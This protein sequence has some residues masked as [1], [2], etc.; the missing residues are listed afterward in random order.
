MSTE[1][2]LH[3]KVKPMYHNEDNPSGKGWLPTI[4]KW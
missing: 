2:K 3:S 1:T 4:C